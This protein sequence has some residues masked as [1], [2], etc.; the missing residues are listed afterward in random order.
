MR[1]VI[2]YGYL[3]AVVLFWVVVFWLS[4]QVSAECRSIRLELREA[5]DCID[6]LKP[7]VARL[8]ALHEAMF[9]TD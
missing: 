6:P 2:E 4:C 5:G 8:S 9:G 1:N 3:V 7:V